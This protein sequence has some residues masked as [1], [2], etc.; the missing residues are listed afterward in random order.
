MKET[1]KADVRL[2]IVNRI[3]EVLTDLADDDEEDGIDLEEIHDQ[4]QNVANLIIES[5]N[6]EIVSSDGKLATVTL[7]DD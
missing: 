7:G 5:L 2:W 6:I 3:A 4:M 1:E